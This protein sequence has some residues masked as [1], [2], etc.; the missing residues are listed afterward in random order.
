MG[1]L[2]S[3]HNLLPENIMGEERDI[4]ACLRRIRNN[5]HGHTTACQMSSVEFE[6]ICNTIRGFVRACLPDW[7]DKVERGILR[8]R[9]SAQ[10]EKGESDAKQSRILELLE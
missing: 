10:F 3:S 7:V 4:V 5:D 6:N 1:L 8:A 9:E 2:Q